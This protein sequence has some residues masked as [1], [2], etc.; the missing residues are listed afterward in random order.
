MNYID[1]N[2]KFYM[3]YCSADRIIAR[4]DD[5]VWYNLIGDIIYIIDIKKH[6]C[7]DAILEETYKLGYNKVYLKSNLINYYE[8]FGAIYMEDLECGEKLYYIECIVKN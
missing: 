3:K 6:R 7:K 4:K 8:K 1:K 5:I 2:N